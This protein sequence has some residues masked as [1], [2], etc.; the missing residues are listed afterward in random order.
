MGGT[1]RERERERGTSWRCDLLRSHQAILTLSANEKVSHNC[2]G[3]RDYTMYDIF[4]YA[5]IIL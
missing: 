3:I 4:V 1:P 2:L 5:A